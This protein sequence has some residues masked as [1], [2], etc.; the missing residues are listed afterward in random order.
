MLHLKMIINWTKK[1]YTAWRSYCKQRKSTCSGTEVAATEMA[2]TEVAATE[3][4]ATEVAATEMAATEIAATK[5]AIKKV[6]GFSLIEVSIVLVIMGVMLGAI[7]KGRD[8]LA[9][10]KAKGTAD[11]FTNIQT[12]ITLYANDYDATILNSPNDVWKKLANAELLESDTPPSSKLG[13]AFSLVKEGEHLVLRLGAGEDSATAFLT[14]AQALGIVARLGNS[15]KVIVRNKS[16]EA[17][18]IQDTSSDKELYTI[19][20]RIE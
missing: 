6:A 3:V 1:K 14:R 13:G 18:S 20:M 9:Q 15:K 17:V 12:I 5:V 10:A 8:V 4:A 2:A 19:E 11:D 16:K 7:L